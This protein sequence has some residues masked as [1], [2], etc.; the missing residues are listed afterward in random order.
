[1][2]R[3]DGGRVDGVEVA[4]AAWMAWRARASTRLDTAR[5]LARSRGDAVA[6]KLRG[7]LPRRAAAGGRD[8]R[9][10]AG[11]SRARRGSM[12]LFGVR[13]WRRAV[14]PGL[15]AELVGRHG[16]R[17]VFAWGAAYLARCASG[18]AGES[19]SRRCCF[20]F[21]SRRAGGVA[22]GRPLRRRR[23]LKRT[24]RGVSGAA[25]RFASAQRRARDAAN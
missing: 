4:R 13:R 2:A 8:P 23:E 20:W 10:A 11:C 14:G 19:E 22:R 3:V 5:A 24:R 9:R 25:S 7:Q 16:G 15:F 21:C 17:L 6:Q 12:D 1:M 18:S